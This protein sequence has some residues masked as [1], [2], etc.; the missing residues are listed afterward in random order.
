VYGLLKYAPEWLRPETKWLF[1]WQDR[2]FDRWVGRHLEAADFIHAMPGQALETF[3]AARWRGIRTVLNHATGPVRAWVRI[4]EPEYARVGLKLTD[5]CPYDDEY[6]A[7]EAEEYAL[8]DFHCAAS[9]VVREQLV[10]E[11]VDPARIWQV[12][13]GAD[14]AIFHGRDARAPDTFRIVFAGQ[15]GLRKGLKTLLDALTLA[16]R[17]DWRADFYG[18][19]LAEARHDAARYTGPTPLKF[20]GAVSQAGLAEAFR[21]GSVVVLPSL[22]EGFGLVVPQALNC[23]VPCLVSDRTGAKDLVRHRENGS[24]FPVQKAEALAAELSW[25]AANPRRVSEK[26]L[27]EGPARTLVAYS[28]AAS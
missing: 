1:R 5:V 14:P 7:R 28:Q 11:G 17:P 22:E 9:S 21:G 20:H 4:M 15:V 2:G 13:Y 3:R 23:G 19:V 24:I 16:K 26:H 18:G 25:W 12:P 6:F 8:A 10:A 27:W